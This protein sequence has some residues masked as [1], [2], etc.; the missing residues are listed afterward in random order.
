M[1]NINKVIESIRKELKE[2]GSSLANFPDYGNMY[3][4]A[5]SVAA[6]VYEQKEKIEQSESS[7]FLNSASGKTLDRKAEDYGMVRKNGSYSIGTVLVTSS[8][9]IVIPKG[10]VLSDTAT[11]IQFITTTEGLVSIPNTPLPIQSLIKSKDANLEAGSVLTSSFFPL[12][13]FIIGSSFN[14]FKREYV[15]DM[16]GGDRVETDSQLKSRILNSISRSNNSNIYYF[17]DVLNNIEQSF[18]YSIVE[19]FPALGYITIYTDVDSQSI[20]NQ[21]KEE[22]NNVKPLGVAIQLQPFEKVEVDINL[23][24]Y[25][26]PSNSSISFKNDLSKLVIERITNYVDGKTAM[27]DNISVE[28]ISSTISKIQEVIDF[29]IRNPTTTIVLSKEQIAKVNNV[30]L[31]YRT[32]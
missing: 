27:D 29:R 19:N 20:L 32:I 5:R 13:S 26:S 10:T 24:L 6:V 21:I 11:A 23:I 12:T 30:T 18:N 16:H 7:I 28:G 14:S 15:G 25:I 31:S 2:Q 17:E 1:D 3:A 8:T 9:S 22:T 4:I